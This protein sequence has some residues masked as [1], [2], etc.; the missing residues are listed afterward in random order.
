M[1][2]DMGRFGAIGALAAV[3]MAGCAGPMSESGSVPA[4]PTAYGVPSD[5]G[6]QGSVYSMLFGRNDGPTTSGSASTPGAAAAPA[7]AATPGTAAAPAT[8]TTPAAPPHPA[9]YGLPSDAGS[10]GSLYSAL[11]SGNDEPAPPGPPPRPTSYGVPSD[12]GSHGSLYSYIFG[13]Q[14]APAKPTNGAAG[15]STAG[16]NP[17]PPR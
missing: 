13:S 3:L 17:P 7:A 16:S 8:P 14:D 9:S 2:Q 12:A 11:F 5:A 4:R 1:T 15:A 6:S 10:H